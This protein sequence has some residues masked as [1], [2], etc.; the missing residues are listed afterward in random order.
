VLA[1]LPGLLSQA[2]GLRG[3]AGWGGLRRAGRV[4]DWLAG[5]VMIACCAR[6]A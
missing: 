4:V 3:F 6:C 1:A 2:A 5:M